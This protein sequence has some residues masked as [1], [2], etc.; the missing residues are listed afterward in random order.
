[1]PVTPTPTPDG[2]KLPQSVKGTSSP[3]KPPSDKAQAAPAKDSKA[4]KPIIGENFQP[5][6]VKGANNKEQ[7]KTSTKKTEKQSNNGSDATAAAAVEELEVKETEPSPAPAPASSAGT[8]QARQDAEQAEEEERMR[9]SGPMEVVLHMPP[10]GGEAGAET[11]AATA[12]QGRDQSRHQHNH[13]LNHFIP[14]RYMHHFDTYTLV[15]Q[16]ETDGY[17]NEQAVTLMKAVRILLAHNLDM[18]Q[19]GL[20]SKR[21]VDNVGLPHLPS[22]PKRKPKLTHTHTTPQSKAQLT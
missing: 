4:S 12:S 19:E 3:P 1:M 16:L 10:P 7:E 5:K 15:K 20:V 13:P 18:A 6:G 17:T 8:A 14:P 9:H 22:S 21:D 11:M 2:G